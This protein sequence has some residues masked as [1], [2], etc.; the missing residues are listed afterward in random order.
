MKKRESGRKAAV[1]K[2]GQQGQLVM[3]GQWKMCAGWRCVP[4]GDG[5][6]E[7]MR[8]EDFGGRRTGDDWR[9]GTQEEKKRS[10][11]Q[12]SWDR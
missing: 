8:K 10:V 1:A 7:K 11:F 2:K 6:R 3:R 9:G 5:G 4:A 12:K